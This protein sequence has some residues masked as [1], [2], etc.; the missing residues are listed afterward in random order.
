M[1][2]CSAANVI[3]LDPSAFSLSTVADIVAL[4]TLSSASAQSI[5]NTTPATSAIQS[6]T[7]TSSLQACASSV[8]LPVPGV[9]LSEVM[10]PNCL[11]ES[12]A[13]SN[14]A[15]ISSAVSTVVAS[16]QNHVEAI[17]SSAS[18]DIRK[19]LPSLSPATVKVDTQCVSLPSKS[20]P[21]HDQRSVVENSSPGTA[22]TTRDSS[23][24]SAAHHLMA[25]QKRAASPIAGSPAKR[26]AVHSDSVSAAVQLETV[27]SSGL[28][29][30][31]GRSSRR[32]LYI[33]KT[34]RS[35]DKVPPQPM[36][37]AL[38]CQRY[39]PTP[40]KLATRVRIESSDGGFCHDGYCVQELWEKLI[41]SVQ[42]SRADHGLPYA[43][44]GISS[45]VLSF[46]GLEQEWVVRLLEQLPSISSCKRYRPRYYQVASGFGSSDEDLPPKENP[47]GC[48]RAEIVKQT[49]SFDMFNFLSSRYRVR[50]SRHTNDHPS[51]QVPQLQTGQPESSERAK[52]TSKDLPLAMRFRQ[53]KKTVKT[54]VDV[55]RSDIHGRGL[56]AKRDIEAQEMVIEY[57][58][59]LI[60]S[61]LTDKREK[62]YE[63]QNIGCY[64]FRI[65]RHDVIDATMCGNAARFI[66]HSCDPNCYSK[67]VVVDGVKK[68]VIFAARQISCGEE[69]TYDYKFAKEEDKIPCTCGADSCRKYLN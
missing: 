30:E 57:S 52:L 10:T 58:G 41:D 34:V 9:S 33:P 22:D 36:T 37:L 35:S 4:S 14:S 1:P 53:L 15:F 29:V 63:K 44:L 18:S 20:S 24:V 31:S 6:T 17:A 43:P 38:P 64:M 11:S 61:E 40:G 16:Q 65:D 13:V 46:I 62:M 56:F 7:V 42:E 47:H 54:M 23:V 3:V 12:T 5:L 69:L 8:E 21:V 49:C 55:Y 39:T 2:V 45:G 67:I 59:Q 28:E 51:T 26:L 19:G 66:N 32:N 25:L 48:A 68:I 60:R 50:P 27:V